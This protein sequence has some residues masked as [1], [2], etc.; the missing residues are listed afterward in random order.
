VVAT[1]R[2]SR[3]LAPPP[4]PPELAAFMDPRGGRPEE[5]QLPA[6]YPRTDDGGPPPAPASWWLGRRI[7]W[8]GPW[9]WRLVPLPLRQ[10][11]PLLRR[12]QIEEPTAQHLDPAAHAL[13]GGLD[14]GEE[15]RPDPARAPPLSCQQSRGLLTST[16]P[17]RW[18][19]QSESGSRSRP[20]P[21]R[22]G[23][24]GGSS[25]FWWLGRARVC[26]SPA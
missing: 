18:P 25:S 16:P 26:T 3:G 11:L 1:S 15:P 10:C 21:P 14:D 6:M 17:P 24:R 20:P 2:R 5:I 22:L 4:L 12:P 23:R 19:P 7:E 13:A 8:L 9:Q